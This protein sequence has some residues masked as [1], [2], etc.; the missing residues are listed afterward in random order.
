[1]FIWNWS[2]DVWSPYIARLYPNNNTGL[3]NLIPL[4]YFLTL[5]WSHTLINR[6]LNSTNQANSSI[7]NQLNHTKSHYVMITL[8]HSEYSAK[9][10]LNIWIRTNNEFILYVSKSK[11]KERNDNNKNEHPI[12]VRDWTGCLRRANASRTLKYQRKQALEWSSQK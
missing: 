9:C 8:S 3:F 7:I 6:S 11:L 2:I 12:H 10:I 5:S 1:M 4:I